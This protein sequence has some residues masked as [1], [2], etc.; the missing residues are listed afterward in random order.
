MTVTIKEVQSSRDVRRFVHYPNA[1]YKGNPYYVPTLE[2]GDRDLLNP[3]KNHAFEFCE[4]KYWLAY[5]N[6]GKIVGRIAGIINHKYNEKVGEKIARFGFMDFIDDNEVVDALFD[7]FTQWARGKGMEILNGPLGFLEFDAS[8]VCVEGYDELPTAY[9]KYNY[10][11]YEPQLLRLGFTKDTDWV[12]YLIKMPETVP[13]T[14]THGAEVVAQRYNLHQA[15]IST[16]KKML[17]YFDRIGALLNKAYAN[18][19]G[20]SELSKGQIEDLKDQFVPM[21][22]EKFVS[23]VLDGNDNVVGFGICAPSMAKAMQKAG[24]KLFPLGFLHVLHALKHNDTLDALLIGIDDEYRN[25]GVSAMIFN[26]IMPGIFSSGIKYIE[27]TRELETN[28][29]VQN[30]WNKFE[31]RLH[32]RARCYI[33]NLK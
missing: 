26:K 3:R 8:G 2:K 4:G 6:N 20:F 11:Y 23:V 25:K 10:P 31:Y 32:K 16:K 14:I 24:G 33:K 28:D 12:E 19:H 21:L 17:S 27:S 13:D 5:D 9:G 18:I 7:T 15:D 29:S 22:S 30:L 1:L